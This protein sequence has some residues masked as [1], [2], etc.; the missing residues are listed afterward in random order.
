MQL[1]KAAYVAAGFVALTLG[2]AGLVV[3]LLPTTPLVLLAAF[4]FSK[5]NKRLEAWLCRSCI[6]GPFIENYRTGQGIGIVHKVATLVFLWAGLGTT[7]W[8]LDQLVLYIFLSCVGVGVTTHILLMKT[9][10]SGVNGD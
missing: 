6:F 4:F 3:P 5:S 7:I 8:L 1:K 10:R 2:T 9:K